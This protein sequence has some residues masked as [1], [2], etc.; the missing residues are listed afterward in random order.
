MRT[1]SVL[2][3]TLVASTAIGLTSCGSGSDR[4][5]AGDPKPGGSAGDELAATHA[6]RTPRTGDLAIRVSGPS[7]IGAAVAELAGTYPIR[8]EL[9]NRGDL[10]L[11]LHD[12]HAIPVVLRDGAPIERC[13]G[14]PTPIGT[15][16]LAVGQSRAT[17]IGLPCALGEGRYQVV[18]HVVVGDPRATA[19]SSLAGPSGAMPLVIDE[20]LPRFV[21][22]P[23]IGVPV[24][25]PSTDPG[26]SP[27]ATP[28]P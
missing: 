5:A 28:L 6:A 24:D 12:A 23:P 2:I 17:L 14:A 13:I 10:A 15:A 9:E 18:V 16:V 7:P 1:H 4:G 3:V 26:L 25:P 27:G 21:G 20:S 22:R 11:D 19:V 8:V